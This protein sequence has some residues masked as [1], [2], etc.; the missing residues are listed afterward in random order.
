MES[1]ELLQGSS[2]SNEDGMSIIVDI[3]L[4]CGVLNVAKE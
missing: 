1:E 3:V 2:D 4:E